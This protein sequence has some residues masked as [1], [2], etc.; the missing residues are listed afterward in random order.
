LPSVRTFLLQ[1]L[2]R[3]H[4]RRQVGLRAPSALTACC[5]CGGLRRAAAPGPAARAGGRRRSRRIPA[6]RPAALQVDQARFVG[7]GQRVAV[8]HQAFA[9]LVQLARLLLDV[10]LVGGQHLDLLLHLRDAPRCSGDLACAWRSASSWSGSCMPAL[11]PARPA[12]W[13]SLRPRRPAPPGSR[14]SLRRF[15]LARGPLGGLFLQL[16][17]ALLDALAAFDHEADLGFQPADFGAG[18]VE[19]ALRL[20]DLVAGGVVRLAHGFQ[21]A[22]D[23]AQVGHARLRGR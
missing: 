17:Q 21:F 23:A 11:R 5:A 8:D 3:L 16:H 18:F 20:V 2:Q 13:P 10:A 1:R 15:V 12:S 19:L 6:R 7:R 14:V 22:F 4:A 9:A